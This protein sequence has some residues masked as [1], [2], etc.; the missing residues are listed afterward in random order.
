M[1]AHCG[2]PDHPVC[3]EPFIDS[4]FCCPTS[5]TCLFTAA[6]TTLVCCPEHTTC[7][8]IR[9]VSCDVSLQVPGTELITTVFDQPMPPCG[10]DCC[11]FGYHCNSDQ[12]C[13]LNEDFNKY[14]PGEEPSSSQ[15]S[16]TTTQTPTASQDDPSM[17]VTITPEP[18]SSEEDLSGPALSSGAIVGI[19]IGS[20]LGLALVLLGLYVIRRVHRSKK[21]KKASR[22]DIIASPSM[23]KPQ[24]AG[25]QPVEAQSNALYELGG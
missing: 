14:P 9:T 10:M 4:D 22:P 24:A 5:R 1:A 6:N 8:K 7:N 3:Q 21:A 2:D 25:N 13:Q 20:A 11:P 23:S 19:G 15:S 18:S 17:T 12:V 16:S